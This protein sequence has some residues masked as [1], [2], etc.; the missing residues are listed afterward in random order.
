MTCSPPSERVL[1][2]KLQSVLQNLRAFQ[3]E[4]HAATVGVRRVMKQ[5]PHG[6]DCG[7]RDQAADRDRMRGAW[8]HT[9][10]RP[11]V[12]MPSKF[13]SDSDFFPSTEVAVSGT[14]HYLSVLLNLNVCDCCGC[15]AVFVTRCYRM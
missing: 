11:L 14:K 8:L 12:G 2:L 15:A 6:R 9:I 7:L 3:S 5:G 13:D 4:K 10:G 1:R